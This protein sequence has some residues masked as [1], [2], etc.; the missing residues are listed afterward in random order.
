[1]IGR[2]SAPVRVTVTKNVVRKAMETYGVPPRK[3]EPGDM[4]PGYAVVAFES[5][6]ERVEGPTLMKNFL[7]ISNELS[8]ER[9]LRLGEELTVSSRLADMSERFG[10]RFGYSIHVRTETVFRDASGAVVARS[11][12][13]G[14]QYENEAP[15]G[16]E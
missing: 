7:M 12:N 2:E 11:A 4:V 6:A 8:F 1:M 3:F 14:M 9:P 5:E 10:G 15:G 13:T 16:G